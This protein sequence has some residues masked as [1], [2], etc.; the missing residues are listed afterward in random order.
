MPNL[1]MDYRRW[2]TIFIV[3]FQ[4]LT[5]DAGDG[6]FMSYFK[7][8]QHWI[9]TVCR[10]IYI[11]RSFFVQSTC[12]KL[13]FIPSICELSKGQILCLSTL[14]ETSRSISMFL[15]LRCLSNCVI[16]GAMNMGTHVVCFTTQIPPRI[17]TNHKIPLVVTLT[18]ESGTI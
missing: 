15:P 1:L 18:K 7:V 17:A 6:N 8:Y 13:M 10:N 2:Y 11:I 16:A 9:W 5:L 14:S 3:K 12:D 4:M